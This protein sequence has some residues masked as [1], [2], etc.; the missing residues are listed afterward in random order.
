MNGQVSYWTIRQASGW[1]VKR[2]GNKE[3][4]SI[5]EQQKEAWKEARRLTG[6]KPAPAAFTP[7]VRRMPA[8]R[9]PA[10]AAQSRNRLASHR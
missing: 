4:S 6:G 1:G 2:Q 5:H 10:Q 3:A 7:P 8:Q 9:M